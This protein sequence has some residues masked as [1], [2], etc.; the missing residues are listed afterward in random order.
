[1][2]GKAQAGV[3]WQSE[4]EFQKQAGHPIEG[5]DIPAADNTTAVY[6]GAVAKNAPHPEAARRWLSFVRSSEG[7]AIFARYGFKPYTGAGK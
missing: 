3:T 2:Q 5:V 4:V 6:A 7:L 1:M